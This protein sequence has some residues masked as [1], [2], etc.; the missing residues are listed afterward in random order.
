LLIQVSY[1]QQTVEAFLAQDALT[2]IVGLVADPLARH[3]RMSE[4]DGLIV[5]LVI[6]FV[7]N[8]LSVPAV[9][10]TAGSR[11]SHRTQ[12]KD[13]LLRRLFDEHVL[14]LLLVVAQHTNE[15]LALWAGWWPCSRGTCM[16]SFSWNV[17]KHCC[18]REA[19][20]LVLD[21]SRG[22]SGNGRLLDQDHWR[23]G[24]IVISSFKAKGCMSNC[25]IAFMRFSKRSWNW[26]E[27][28]VAYWRGRLAELCLTAGGCDRRACPQWRAGSLPNRGTAA[29]GGF[30]QRL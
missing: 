1:Q 9:R 23:L 10:P 26:R 16:S 18:S 25:G 14:E 13:D 3:P 17:Q 5:Q 19:A 22:M 8:L 29:S 7:R 27:N 12:L 28:Y 11:G 20:G 30:P 4:E 24:T 6:A 15:V 2:V 21:T